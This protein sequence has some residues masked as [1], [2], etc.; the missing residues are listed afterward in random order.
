MNWKTVFKSD[1]EVHIN[2][3]IAHLEKE[4]I[5]FEVLN[6]KDSSY[7]F[8]GMAEVLVPTDYFEKAEHELQSLTL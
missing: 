5:P 1:N 8:L 2:I 6:K 3:V 4:A 7:V